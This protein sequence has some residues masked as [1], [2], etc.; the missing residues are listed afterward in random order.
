MNT[1]AQERR[2]SHAT[3]L[4]LLFFISIL[5]L[6]VFFGLF[7]IDNGQSLDS[8]VLATFIINGLLAL[9]CFTIEAMR[10]PY[11]LCQVHW[12]F[13]LVFFVVAPFSQYCHGYNPWGYVLD[14]SNRLVANALLM[15]WAIL[16]FTFSSLRAKRKKGSRDSGK[17]EAS[18]DWNRYFVVK[19]LPLWLLAV[20]CAAVIF[21]L[22]YTLEPDQLISRSGFSFGFSGSLGTVGERFLRFI[23]VFLVVY[24]WIH[25]RQ[26]RRG[27]PLLLLSIAAL[28]II[29]F[30]TA[31]ARYSMATIYGG[32]LLTM[33]EPLRRNKMLFPAL[34]LLALLFVF[35]LLSSLRGA[36]PDFGLVLSSLAQAAS[37]LPRSFCTNDYDAYSMFARA[38]IYV[39]DNGATW[40][41]QLLGVLLFFVPRTMWPDKPVGSGAMIATSQDQSFVNVACPLPGETAV[42]FGIVGIVLVPII[43][44]LLFRSLDD[45]H[46]KSS[47]PIALFHPFFCMMLFFLL[48]GDL[49]SGFAYLAG[50]F[51]PFLATTLFV[52]WLSR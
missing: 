24:S 42:N 7:S 23:P 1:M 8:L 36:T 10:R 47:S 11:S 19:E 39:A 40:G 5:V 27:L 31:M 3:I 33:V 9:L 21:Y 17:S 35:P 43:L 25:Y 2:Y 44:G 13:F 20:V 22:L 28:L 50:F 29:A 15:L 32:L 34:L 16:F 6:L 41:Y 45:W 18:A 48:R 26:T 30:P 51:V 37:D 49:M 46:F 4:G 38:L 52:K 12:L 14:D